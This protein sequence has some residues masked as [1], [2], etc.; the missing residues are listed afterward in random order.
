[1][2]FSCHHEKAKNGK[3]KFRNTFLIMNIPLE[4]EMKP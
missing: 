2:T 4:N 3:F 1:M